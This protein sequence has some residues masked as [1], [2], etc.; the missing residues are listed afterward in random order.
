MNFLIQFQCQVKNS[1]CPE[2][3]TSKCQDRNRTIDCKHYSHPSR[4]DGT[5]HGEEASMGKLWRCCSPQL[6]LQPCP[7]CPA[8]RVTHHHARGTGWATP[9]HGSLAL[10]PLPP[11]PPPWPLCPYPW[12]FHNP[13]TSFFLP[14]GGWGVGRSDRRWISTLAD[15]RWV[16]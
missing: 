9:S 2:P 1:V 14:T 12:S 3:C 4:T 10:M 15:T 6:P 16:Q 7:P 5:M 13:A 8:P 11:P